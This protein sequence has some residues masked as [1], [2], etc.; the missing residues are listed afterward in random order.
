[1]EW[2]RAASETWWCF[3]GLLPAP[4]STKSSGPGNR[5]VLSSRLVFCQIPMPFEHDAHS[6]PKNPDP[7]AARSALNWQRY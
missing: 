4:E 6:G 3:Q 2:N 5:I 7:E 1:L